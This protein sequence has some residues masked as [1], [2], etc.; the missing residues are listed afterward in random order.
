MNW[1]DTKFR[2]LK[3]EGA[4]ND[5]LIYD[6]EFNYSLNPDTNTNSKMEVEREEEKIRDKEKKKLNF[7]KQNRLKFLADWNEQRVK[8]DDFQR[9]NLNELRKSEQL[10]QKEKDEREKEVLN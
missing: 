5:N 7:L 2:L 6:Y 10:K 8:N 1:E 9:K 3:N 4:L